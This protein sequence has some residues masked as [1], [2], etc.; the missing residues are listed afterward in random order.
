VLALRTRAVAG[1]WYRASTSDRRFR[2]PFIAA[3]DEAFA[4]GGCFCLASLMQGYEA[5]APPPSAAPPVRCA[6]VVGGKD[7]THRHS[8]FTRAVPQA[9]VVRFDDCGHSPELEAPERF[10]SWLLSWVT[11]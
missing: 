4:F 6:V 5:S 8:D 9:E 2:A 1:G 3:A 11:P 7:R 10:A